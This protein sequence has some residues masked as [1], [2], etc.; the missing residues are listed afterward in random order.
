[1]AVPYNP[2]DDLQVSFYLLKHCDLWV[3]D[4]DDTLIDTTTYYVQDMSPT[5]IRGRT[6]EEL[7]RE[8]EEVD[9]VYKIFE[10]NESVSA[11][12]RNR[13]KNLKNINIKNTGDI[14]KIHRNTKTIYLTRFA[15]ISLL[16]AANMF[17]YYFS[18]NQHKFIKLIKN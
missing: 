3:W 11:T 6:D 9:K 12:L 2:P 5:A 7:D 13:H 16:L 14:V 4:F 17:A 18:I 15:F 8:L 10:E 1:M